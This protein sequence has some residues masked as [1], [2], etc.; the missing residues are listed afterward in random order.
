M[1]TMRCFRTEEAHRHKPLSPRVLFTWV[2]IA[3]TAAFGLSFA[4]TQQALAVEEASAQPLATAQA[5]IST[6]AAEDDDFEYQ[7]G[8][9]YYSNRTHQYCFQYDDGTW[10]VGWH[11][12]GDENWAEIYYFDNAGWMVTGW[13]RIE[14]AWYYFHNSGALAT[15]WQK[16]GGTWYYLGPDDAAMKTGWQLINGSWYYFNG[17]G[18]MQVGWQKIG[19]SW[20]FLRSSGVMA[21]GWQQVGAKW[22]LFKSSGAMATGWQQSSSDWY[23]LDASG[24]MKTGWQKVGASWYYLK[25]SGAMATG[26]QKIGGAWYYLKPSGAMATGWQQI[27]NDWYH[28]QSSGVMSSRTWI[29]DYFVYSSGAMAKNTWIGG[30]YVGADGKWIPN[31]G[32]QTATPTT[33][34]WTDGGKVYHLTQN[35]ASLK[36]AKNI[37]SGTIAQSGKTRVCDVCS[38]R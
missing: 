24:A 15:D 6:M 5:E 18:A 4:T 14:G 19:A 33:V 38:H 7:L 1:M 26:W 2:A 35:C 31:Y 10:A 12:I 20:Y 23:Y 11:V 22:Y 21:T 25:G 30:Y 32:S 3:L 9:W 16:I 29:G 36:N 34:Y 37:K 17:S 8:T 28:L 27:G 13:Q